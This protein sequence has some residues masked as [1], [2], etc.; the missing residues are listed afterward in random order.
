MAIDCHG[1]M[2]VGDMGAG[3][4]IDPH[5]PHGIAAGKSARAHM[6]S[7]PER[8]VRSN[9]WRAMPMSRSM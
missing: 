5:M 6:S 2:G 1:G 3:M 8:P 9:S 7:R 4:L